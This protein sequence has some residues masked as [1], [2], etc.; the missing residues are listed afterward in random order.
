MR[1]KN[2]IISGVPQYC[3]ILWRKHNKERHPKDSCWFKKEI[4]LI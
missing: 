1:R 3:C 2:S 4:K